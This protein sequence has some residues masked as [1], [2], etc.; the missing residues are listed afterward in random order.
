MKYLVID[1]DGMEEKDFSHLNKQ[2]INEE[3]KKKN[4]RMNH[5]KKSRLELTYE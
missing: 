4:L 5:N 2:E 1:E 3:I